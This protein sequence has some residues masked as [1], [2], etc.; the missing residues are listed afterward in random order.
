MPVREALLQLHA[1]G[2]IEMQPNRGA[3]V[4][5][6]GEDDVVEIF[7]L[8]EQIETYLLTHA[9]PRHDAKS[10]ARVAATQQELEVENSRAGW[11]DGDRRFH[12]RLY[13]PAARPRA[14]GLA[15]TL[16]AQV[17]RFCLRALTPDSRRVE[18]AKEHRE[19]IA[20]ARRMDVT[21]GIQALEEH[22]RRTKGE[23]LDRMRAAKPTGAA[24]VDS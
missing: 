24:P 22:L 21:A 20:A 7:D 19:L 23:V 10:L 16:R 15:Q 6:L 4:A 11:L 18:W 3:V 9:F 12:A 1:E 17:E 14:L 5:Q 8:R 13:E 2:L